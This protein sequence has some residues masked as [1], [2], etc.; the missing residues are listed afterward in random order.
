MSEGLTIR[1]IVENI[2]RG[3]IRIP[4]FQRGFVWDANRVAFFMDSIYKG[5]PFGSFLENQR[6]T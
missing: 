1:Q 5:Y 3:Q 2:Q 4:A 6:A